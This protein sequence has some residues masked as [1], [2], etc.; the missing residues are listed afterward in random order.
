MEVEHR[1]TERIV[2]VYKDLMLE[3]KE[4]IS[5]LEHY[6]HTSELEHKQTQKKVVD[7]EKEVLS[8]RH[9]AK[10][11]EERV[12]HSD[13]IAKTINS[14]LKQAE[15][16]LQTTEERLK[17]TEDQLKKSTDKAK[18]TDACLKETISVLKETEKRLREYEQKNHTHKSEDHILET[19]W[20]Q[21]LNVADDRLKEMTTRLEASEL[22]VIKLETQ[23]KEFRSMEI[24][25]KRALEKEAKHDERVQEVEENATVRIQ[26][27]EQQLRES[28]QLRQER[29]VVIER[30]ADSLKES[31]DRIEQSSMVEKDLASALFKL[32]T[33]RKMHWSVGGNPDQAIQGLMEQLHNTQEELA[34]AKELLRVNEM[35]ASVGAS[36]VTADALPHQGKASPRGKSSMIFIN[37]TVEDREAIMRTKVYKLLEKETSNL[38]AQLEQERVWRLEAEDMLHSK[39]E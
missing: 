1:E 13:G 39:T 34:T 9:Y 19:L 38:I 15:G 21:K 18:A 30:L 24:N 29:E 36:P 3:Y 31:T 28:E 33:F 37:G 5:M 17:A 11:L 10:Q 22:H 6:N 27:L 8:S 35:R 32:D 26:G 12:S 7:L 2:A 20:A 16:R 23:L 14:L 25:L 4:K